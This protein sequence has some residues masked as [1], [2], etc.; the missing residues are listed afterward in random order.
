MRDEVILKA[1]SFDNDG[2]IRRLVEEDL[3]E[4]KV[5]RA[6]YPFAEKPDSIETLTPDDIFRADKGE[7]GDFFRYI[8]Y[9]LKYLGELK[10]YPK[11]YIEI[12]S[13]LDLFK[14]LLY[15]SV[16][17][18][19]SLAD[20]VDAPWGKIKGLGGDSHIAKKIIFCLNYETGSVVPIFSTSHMEYFL[21][22]IQEEPWSPINYATMSLGEK[23]EA[24]T[25]EILRAKETS[26]I[27]R[28]WEITYFCRFLYECYTP[29]KIIRGSTPKE[30]EGRYGEKEKIR[31]I[32]WTP[33][34]P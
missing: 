5:F 26:P 10:T 24:L 17:R 3:K 12:R 9:R 23:Y 15:I 34:R 1:R 29:P 28:S 11:V 33:K 21:D 32:H 22:T 6:K 20:K 27:T 2:A 13:H 31:R 16:D 19:R 4:L 25:E 30:Y 14:D 8:E 7:I 18:K